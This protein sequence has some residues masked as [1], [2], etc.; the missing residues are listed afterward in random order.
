MTWPTSRLRPENV[1][2]WKAPIILDLVNSIFTVDG[3]I[4]EISA[5]VSSATNQPKQENKNLMKTYQ[6]VW[7]SPPNNQHTSEL[8]AGAVIEALEV[9]AALKVATD[10]AK[11]WLPGPDEDV[12][13][14]YVTVAN[15]NDD[16]DSDGQVVTC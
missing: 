4:Y 1:V 11:Q 3:K 2:N 6:I 8:L 15:V 7:D 13:S 9:A 12:N 5:E 16:D 10:N 14:V